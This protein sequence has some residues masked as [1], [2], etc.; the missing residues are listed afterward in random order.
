MRTELWWN[1]IYSLPWL[2]DQVFVPS[3]IPSSFLNINSWRNRIEI[4]LSV[5][6]FLTWTFYFNFKQL[7]L[8]CHF[9]Y[10]QGSGFS[11][12]SAICIDV[13]GFSFQVVLFS[14]LASDIKKTRFWA[15]M[16]KCHFC[17]YQFNY[18]EIWEVEI[19]ILFTSLLCHST[20]YI[21]WMEIA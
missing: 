16:D 10:I 18:W 12:R 6:R 9:V 8:S 11:G 19:K 4:L 2:I 13:H 5:I 17:L 15:K 3:A 21:F 7:I 14:L 1:S 20:L